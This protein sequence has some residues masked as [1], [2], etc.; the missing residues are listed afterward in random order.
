MSIAGP[1]LS[2]GYRVRGVASNQFDVGGV[3]PVRVTTAVARSQRPS[4]LPE[5]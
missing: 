1:N 3:V 2:V 5:K 4:L